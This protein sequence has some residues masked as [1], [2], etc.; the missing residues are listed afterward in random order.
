MFQQPKIHWILL[1]EN[2]RNCPLNLLLLRAGGR[3]QT[4]HSVSQDHPLRKKQTNY[5]IQDAT[6]CHVDSFPDNEFFSGLH[7]LQKNSFSGA[8]FSPAMARS[9]KNEPTF[10]YGSS[11]H[12]KLCSVKIYLTPS[13]YST[14]QSERIPAVSPSIVCSSL[15]SSSPNR[16][17]KCAGNFHRG[18]FT[19]NGQM[20]NYQIVLCG[21]RG[22]GECL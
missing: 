14:S 5:V 9:I 13:S 10:Y 18:G 21:P 19:P 1:T 6:L 16:S 3:Q 11:D 8:I 17:W 2:K 7:T 12:N 4:N 15:S 22:S 20:S